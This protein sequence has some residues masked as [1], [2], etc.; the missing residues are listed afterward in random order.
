MV[1]MRTQ[2]TDTMC[3]AA[4]ELFGF[5]EVLDMVQVHHSWTSI[6]NHTF[7]HGDFSRALYA[8]KDV[9]EQSAN[10]AQTHQVK[11]STQTCG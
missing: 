9:A 11:Y 8:E 5:S 7:P 4:A 3:D 1:P 2:S 10:A 6:L